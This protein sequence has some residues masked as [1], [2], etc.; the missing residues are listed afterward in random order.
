MPEIT[1]YADSYYSMTWEGPRGYPEDANAGRCYITGT[2]GMLRFQGEPDV[3]FADGTSGDGFSFR[4][5]PA[6]GAPAFNGGKGA[7][8]ELWEYTPAALGFRGLWEEDPDGGWDEA[9]GKLRG[10]I[11]RGVPVQIGTHYSLILPYGAKTSPRLAYV[12]SVRPG[13]GFGH[14]I[15]IA[16]YDLHEGTVTVYEP[17]DVMPHSRYQAPIKV[18]RRAWEE[19]AQR[20][21]G[22]YVPWPNHYPW[23]G[24]WSLHDGY[25][26]YQMMWIEP[27]RD[28]RW[29]IA[30]S[31]RDSYRRN[32]KILRGEYPKPYAI[33]ASQWQIPRIETG[34][35]GMVRC[36]EAI[37]AGKLKDI[38]APNGRT[39]KLF[40]QG[41]IPNHGVLGR[42]GATGY[43]RRVAKELSARG[44]RSSDVAE[45]AERMQE[46]SNLFRK[47]RYEEN[48][49]S[50]GDL[51]G[52]I[53]DFEIAAMEL[54]EHGYPEVTAMR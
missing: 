44:L 35:P 46:S 52:R 14:H 3:L 23:R 40:T 50:A 8:H 18:F 29:D 16:G 15:V 2:L 51:L 11:D 28:P 45:A 5:C 53:A 24:E 31:I 19:A 36:A 30:A 37:R 33:F 12:N 43:L 21:G 26:P 38:V 49:V 10:L 42:A 20:E 7:F 27:G 25:G 39:L 1:S 13:P 54:M 34:A 17:N 47:L 41:Q 9:W 22:H 32:L 4:W 6:W 48:L